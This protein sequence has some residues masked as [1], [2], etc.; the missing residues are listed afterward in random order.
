MANYANL[1]S[2]IS[3]DDSEFKAGIRRVKLTAAAASRTIGNGFRSMGKG[4]ASM[5]SMIAGVV[6]SLS[7]F[8]AIAAGI[9]FAAAIAGAAKLAGALRKAFDT[10]GALSDLSSRTGIAVKELVILER[11][12]EDNGLSADKVGTSVNKLQ[13]SIGDLGDGL[14]TQVRAFEALGITYEMI[15]SQSPLEQFRMLEERLQRIEDPTKRA[16][17]AMNIFGR[18]GGELLTLFSDSGAIDRAAQT[19]GGQA[20][21][22]QKNAQTFDRISDLLN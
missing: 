5:A 9:T 22:L 12:F 3:L 8:A 10:G 19:M 11:A 15:E 13:K 7:K 6:R 1:K 14:S 16:A 21:L 18:S 2:K 20:D 17:I 4:L